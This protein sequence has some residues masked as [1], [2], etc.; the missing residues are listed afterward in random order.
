MKNLLIFLFTFIFCSFSSIS[1]AQGQFKIRND[2]FIHVG[3]D[4]YKS[5]TFG[6]QNTYLPNNG[7]YAIEAWNNGL[8][9]WKPW[10]NPQGYGN[11]ILYLRP[12]KNV[13]IG[14][15]GSSAYK[16]YVAGKIRC[17][18]LTE[19]SD[20]RLKRNIN[21]LSGSLSKLMVLNPIS[22]QFKTAT[23][24]NNDIDKANLSEVKL[25]TMEGDI[26]PQDNN[27]H[28]GLSAQDVKKVLPELVTE[29]ENGMLGIRYSGMIPLLIDALKEQQAQIE[30]LKAEVAALKK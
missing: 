2:A 4:I 18:T 23:P 25:K 15:Q 3:Y 17:T 9:F 14:S 19:T 27:T 7:F 28:I 12:D 26:N 30:A 6:N 8:N 16:L 22:Y 11:Y 5:I 10:P 1:I 24:K 29:D 20:I 21:P 13:G